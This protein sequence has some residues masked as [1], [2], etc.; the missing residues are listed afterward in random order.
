MV[1]LCCFVPFASSVSS[2]CRAYSRRAFAVLSVPFLSTVFLLA[3]RLQHPDPADRCC[4][5]YR[6]LFLGSRSHFPEHVDP[7]LTHSSWRHASVPPVPSSP[8]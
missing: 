7:R 5:C 6:V 1:P 3:V 2:P 8:P 4:C